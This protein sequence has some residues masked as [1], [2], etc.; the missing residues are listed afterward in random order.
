MATFRERRKDPEIRERL[1]EQQREYRLRALAD[2]G[3]REAQLARE[4]RARAALVKRAKQLLAE[5]RAAG[6]VVCGEM[7]AACLDAHHVDPS[8]KD[9][10]VSS[11]AGQPVLL[12]EELKKCVCLCA[13]C[14]RKLHAGLINIAG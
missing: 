10:N 14:H 8:E 1:N 9:A 2:P 3:R 7:E 12:A 11:L 13:N 5:F 4:R 6:C